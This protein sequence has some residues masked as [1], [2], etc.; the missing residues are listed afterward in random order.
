M[1]DAD[2]RRLA[3]ERGNRASD[4]AR[5]SLLNAAV[6][7][8]Y[9]AFPE[10]AACG[11]RLGVLSFL[12]I[13][14]VIVRWLSSICRARARQGEKHHENIDSGRMPSAWSDGSVLE[15]YFK[16]SLE[17]LILAQDERWRRA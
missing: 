14:C 4:N 12:K 11:V 7:G 2:S 1:P 5:F 15:S 17:S 9:F 13:E 16:I 8:L 3:G 6:C 10:N